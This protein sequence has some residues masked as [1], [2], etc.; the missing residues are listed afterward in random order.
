MDEHQSASRL[1]LLCPGRSSI[2]LLLR[3]NHSYL[4]DRDTL[5]LA[6][7]EQATSFGLDKFIGGQRPNQ[8]PAEQ[9]NEVR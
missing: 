2:L 1:Q 9:G 5:A 4:C 8:N 3:W 7:L 6:E